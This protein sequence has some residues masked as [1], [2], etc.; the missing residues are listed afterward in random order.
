VSF[1][2]PIN[3]VWTLYLFTSSITLCR[4]V[5][6][7]VRGIGK[8]IVVAGAASESLTASTASVAEDTVRIVE[9]FAKSIADAFHVDETMEKVSNPPFSAPKDDKWETVDDWRHIPPSSI[10]SKSSFVFYGT[11]DEEGSHLDLDSDLPSF[12]SSPTVKE[13][14][15]AGDSV[16][17][18]L[19]HFIREKALMEFH[20]ATEA[21]EGIPALA[22]DL[23]GV[24]FI[25]FISSVILLRQKRQHKGPHDHAK[26][27]TATTIGNQSDGVPFQKRMTIFTKRTETTGH[28]QEDHF[29]YVCTN[30]LFRLIKFSFLLP[31]RILSVIQKVVMN[32]YVLL[33]TI[34]F[35]GGW[36]LCNSSQSRS[37]E[38]QRCGHAS[39]L[40]M[41]HL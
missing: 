27:A 39:L 15:S 9:E 5:S 24:L 29:I 16:Y 32:R 36:L 35:L 8:S 34:H 20:F 22:P 33:F 41:I 30:A 14:L 4:L 7:V 19:F 26:Q 13:L 1:H 31:I 18:T 28:H 37:L 2:G 12:L 6:S 25:C 11:D 40:Y 38:I 10:N 17:S 21:T 3:T 23:L